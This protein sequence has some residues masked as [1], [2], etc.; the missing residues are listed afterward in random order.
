MNIFIIFKSL[1]CYPKFFL[2]TYLVVCCDRCHAFTSSSSKHSNIFVSKIHGGKPMINISMLQDELQ[3][4]VSGTSEVQGAALVSPDGLALASV[5]PSA[6]DEERTAA[7]SASIL[8]LGERIGRELAR[9]N[10]ER[11]VVE[12]EKGYGVLVSCGTDAVLL[13]LAGAEVKQGLLFLEVKRAVS[14][15]APL[16]N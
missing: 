1:S 11:I 6:M 13:V 2:V 4:F 3:N 14:R 5:L 15:I 12:G 9:G 16:L 10:V 8:S 7:M